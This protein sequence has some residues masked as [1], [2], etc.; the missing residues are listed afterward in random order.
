MLAVSEPT[1]GLFTVYEPRHDVFGFS[2]AAGAF[3]LL[4]AAAARGVS[5]MLPKSVG[6]RLFADDVLMWGKSADDVRS[7][8]ATATKTFAA[9]GMPF[10]PGKSAIP[11]QAI[12]YLGRRVSTSPAVTVAL[13][14]DKL[15][16]AKTL[17]R[18]FAHGA[19]MDTR[20]ASS[21]VGVCAEAFL[22]LYDPYGVATAATWAIYSNFEAA[23]WLSHRSRTILPSPTTLTAPV[24]R[25]LVR[26]ADGS[27]LAGP[28]TTPTRTLRW[29]V[30]VTDASTTG[31]GGFVAQESLW[32]SLACSLGSRL[33]IPSATLEED[34][35]DEF[36]GAS[37][38]AREAGGLA[39]A[40]NTLDRHVG[41]TILVFATDSQALVAAL[42][43][44]RSG[45]RELGPILETILTEAKFRRIVILP[46]H[47]PRTAL[48]DADVMSRMHDVPLTATRLDFRRLDTSASDLID[49]W[50]QAQAGRRGSQGAGAVPVHSHDAGTSGPRGAPAAAAVGRDAH[51]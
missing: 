31:A 40:L 46:V 15:A 8:K 11:S 7:A 32:R 22:G 3:I 14:D 45:S 10:K 9:A 21:A 5:T 50:G 44:R 41:I 19:E 20:T 36:E 27:N 42:L 28:S 26:L 47:V 12:E 2:W 17:L 18:A 25:A 24:H 38:A 6:I 30:A 51:H 48:F 35:N 49:S 29:A 37:S 39:A 43:K 34:G 4:A 33:A 23:P 1:T 13:A 16:T